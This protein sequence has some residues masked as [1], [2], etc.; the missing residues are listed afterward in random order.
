MAM[1]G[2][3]IS[4]LVAWIM[5]WHPGANVNILVLD[6]EVYSNTGGQASKVHPARR[7]GQIRGARQSRR[8]RK[9]WVCWP[10][11]MAPSMSRV[12]RWAPTI[13]KRCAPSIEAEA[14][15][16]PSLIIAYSHCIA[17]GIEMSKGL[18]QQ[19]LAVQS[20]YW[21]LYRYNPPGEEGKN[22]LILDSK[23]PTIPLETTPIM[24]RAIGCCSRATKHG[25]K[26]SCKR[27]NRT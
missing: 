20:G 3:M 18:E 1:A 23:D 13:S 11:P 4:A 12:S 27:P 25:P 9:I 2:P 24:R 16:G 10:W 21:P 15:D 6:T 8:R 22:P 5:S 17:H 19:K 26:S 14:Y 7:R